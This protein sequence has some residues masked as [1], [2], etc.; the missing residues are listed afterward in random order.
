[1]EGIVAGIPPRLASHRRRRRSCHGISAPHFLPHLPGFMLG[2]EK[3]LS[4]RI[5]PISPFGVNYLNEL[6]RE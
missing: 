4:F 2:G 3:S 1:M 6:Q 5:L